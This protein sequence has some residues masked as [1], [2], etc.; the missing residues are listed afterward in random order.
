M[1]KFGDDLMAAKRDPE[2]H[3][4]YLDSL[5]LYRQLLAAEPDDPYYR[6]LAAHA[7]Y[8]AGTS[9][10]RVGEKATARK[11]FEDGLKLRQGPAGAVSPTA[12]CSC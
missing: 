10:L 3:R 5:R 12:P 11:T 6:G 1:S 2:G 8:R 7:Y 4:H 9:Y